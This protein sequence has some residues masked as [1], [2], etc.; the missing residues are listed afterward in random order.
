MKE[1]SIIVERAVP[2]M[3]CDPVGA[4]ILGK[5]LGERLVSVMA[6][7]KAYLLT[8]TVD[9]SRD[10]LEQYQ[11][12]KR[13]IREIFYRLRKQGLSDQYFW[14][15]EVTEAGYP[16]WHCVV[17][18]SR[19][20]NLA[21][22]EAVLAVV[23]GCWKRV[24][25]KNGID[26]KY[27]R[28]AG[29]LAYVCKYVSKSGI[30][31]DWLLDQTQV[32]VYQSSSGFFSSERSGCGGDSL[33]ESVERWGRGDVRSRWM[34]ALS[35]CVITDSINRGDRSRRVFSGLPMCV[36][37]MRF[38]R[39]AWVLPFVVGLGYVHECGDLSGMESR[40]VNQW[41]MDWRIGV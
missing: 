23:Y 22:F 39:R 31:P 16:H 27:I 13:W 15:L 41:K 8:L 37:W 4:K 9:H 29:G 14:K 10:P 2:R 18:V 11:V 5:K 30:W 17:P 6:G 35:R 40:I 20:W 28:N 19:R 3:W 33:S 21:E 38:L 26:I 12:G 32:R 25:D 24:G 34:R 7:R 36:D 1:K